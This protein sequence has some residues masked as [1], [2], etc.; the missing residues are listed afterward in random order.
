LRTGFVEGRGAADDTE[1][2]GLC[3]ERAEEYCPK[4]AP[5]V[6]DAEN[7]DYGSLFNNLIKT[8][9]G[10]DQPERSVHEDRI[11][12]AGDRETASA[13]ACRIEREVSA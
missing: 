9:T 11:P 4:I 13:S 12:V 6:D 10:P 3:S 5:A 8:T 7:L 2:F 1:R